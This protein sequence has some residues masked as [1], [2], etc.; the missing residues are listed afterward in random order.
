[1]SPS[2]LPRGFQFLSGLPEQ[3]RKERVIVPIQAFIDDSGVKGTDPVFVLAGQFTQALMWAEFADAWRAALSAQPAIRYFK[4]NEAAKLGGQFGRFKPDERDEK[5]QRLARVISRYG[6]PAVHC[7]TRLKPFDKRFGALPKPFRDP[8]F[9][10][11]HITI[12]AVCSELL[13]RGQRTPFE[14]FFD[15][16]VIFGPRARQWYP[17]V[18]QLLTL[19]NHVAGQVLPVEPLFRTDE[20]DMSLQAADMLDM[21]AWFFRRRAAESD[22]DDDR[23]DWLLPTLFTIPVSKYSTAMTDELW[24]ATFE[25]TYTPSVIDE[26][27]RRYDELFGA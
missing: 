22:P 11:F 13:E 24:K 9:M 10:P 19:T 1:V 7:T 6:F 15:E 2:W 3:A 25:Q 26:I 12:L 4:M 5:L 27:V 14:I 20:Q 17:I 8:Y 18:R 23:F 16:H 21:L